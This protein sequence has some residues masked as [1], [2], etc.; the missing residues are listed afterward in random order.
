MSED[1]STKFQGKKLDDRPKRVFDLKTF[2]KVS[3]S[4]I[5]LFII[6]GV[7]LSHYDI[8]IFND[9]Y[10]REDGLIEWL[11]VV[12]LLFGCFVSIYRARLLRPFRGLA[13]Q[14]SLFI[15]AGL[16]FFG[17][18]EEISWG[19]RLFDWKSPAFFAHNNSQGETNLHNLVVGG[20]KLN[21]LIFGL[22]LGIS[23]VFYFLILPFLYRTKEGVQKI[24]DTMAIP[25][26][27]W[28]HVVAYV[29]LAILAEFIAGHKKG[30]ILEF[31]GC[32]IF[33][34]MFLEPLNRKIYSRLTIER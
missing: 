11:T 2:E 22:L 9:W 25:I 19:Q 34:L 20:V 15:L 21:K 12:A 6:F 14:V 31:G 30:E 5:F 26:P 17:A 13:F 3:F 33:V 8:K 10:V 1:D 16:F 24:I 7:G 29:S 18:G 32:W 27:R 28:F 23:I 4:I